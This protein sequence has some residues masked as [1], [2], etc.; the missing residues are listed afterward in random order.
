MLPN[1]LIKPWS[2][3]WKAGLFLFGAFVVVLSCFIAT[4]GVSF[5]LSRYLPTDG[6]LIERFHKHR[7]ACE[8]IA[9]FEQHS[10]S[11]SREA[12]ELSRHEIGA[13]FGIISRPRYVRFDVA[14][15]GFL[16]KGRCKGY[17][18]VQDASDLPAGAIVRDLDAFDE[19][20]GATKA[21][22][23]RHLEGSWYLILTIDR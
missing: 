21:E 2:A 20:H 1:S 15:S 3:A 18:W 13:R 23:Y 4:G 10:C 22:A 11:L 8:D 6:R 5:F 16:G 12:L 14:A 19:A 9:C 7:A 17:A